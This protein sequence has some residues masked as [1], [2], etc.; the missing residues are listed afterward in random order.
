MTECPSKLVPIGF[1]LPLGG[2]LKIHRPFPS[3]IPLSILF[4]A[5]PSDYTGLG[6][7]L[8]NYLGVVP[9]LVGRMD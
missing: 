8:V 4:L 6:I 2:F 5:Y 3:Y 9:Y 7:G 1:E